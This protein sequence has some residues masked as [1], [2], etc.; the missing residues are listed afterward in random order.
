MKTKTIN[1]KLFIVLISFALIIP[2]YLISVQAQK[3]KKPANADQKNPVT[4]IYYK[5][6]IWIE[7]EN[8][9]DTNFSKEKTYNFFCSDRYALT[10]FKR[11]RPGFRQRILCDLCVLC[12]RYKDVRFLDGV[13]TARFKTSGQTGICLSF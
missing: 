12:S 4:K 2:F 5:N 11:C 1:S 7:G 6:Y 8:S 10:A 3:Q 9:V 13:H